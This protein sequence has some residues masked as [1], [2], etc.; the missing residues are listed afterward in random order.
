V[1]SVVGQTGAVTG[2][3][4]AADGAVRAAFVAQSGPAVAAGRPGVFD[5]R[6]ATYNMT[7]ANF[8]RGRAAIA[9]A[10]A[11]LGLCD[12]V[13]YGDSR[14]Q[15]A[16]LAPTTKS[17]QTGW[18]ALL[19]KRLTGSTDGG[20]LP[21]FDN[22]ATYDDRFSQSGTW[23]LQ[24]GGPFNLSLQKS[25]AATV[26]TETFTGTFDSIA[27]YFLSVAVGGW[28]YEYQLDGGAWTTF[29]STASPI[30]GSAY[31]RYVVT[32]T[33]GA[34]TISVRPNVASGASL[35]LGGME[36][37]IGSTGFRVHSIARAGY[38]VTQLL[39]SDGTGWLSKECTWLWKAPSIGIVD[40]AI[41]SYNNQLAL[42]TFKADTQVVIDKIKIS[43]DPVLVAP[44]A[45]PQGV[46]AIPLAS[47]ISTY[48]DLADS[49]GIPLID[50]NWYFQTDAAWP[51]N[52]SGYM[53]DGIHFT[54]LGHSANESVIS[55][56]LG[57]AAV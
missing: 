10:R 16:T 40:L 39:L 26:G 5:P 1:S 6:T 13:A 33:L 57:L 32:T 37:M 50:L 56:A 14:T 36:P 54:N 38:E 46:G 48:Y 24:G 30:A 9:K 7:P 12:I 41:N 52:P 25:T 8:R 27:I 45:Y 44:Y 29:P 53:G 35:Y 31:C 3:Q 15:G 22:I 34:H 4:I 19:R 42:A 20:L 51:S 47:Y 18:P 21:I 17:Y 2:A 43:G 28:L 23:T 11:G 49:N 55:H